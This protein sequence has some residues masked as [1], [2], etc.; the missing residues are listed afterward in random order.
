VA[1]QA[2]SDA[3]PSPASSTHLLDASM[4]NGAELAEIFHS[5]SKSIQAMSNSVT[6]SFVP[7]NIPGRHAVISHSK[8]A[9]STGGA[10]TS[11]SSTNLSNIIPKKHKFVKAVPPNSKILTTP[12][13]DEW[14]LR[15][16]P[17]EEL[18]TGTEERSTIESE[19]SS[20]SESEQ[21]TEK[22]ESSSGS[23]EDAPASGAQQSPLG[24]QTPTLR[25]AWKP[26]ITTHHKKIKALTVKKS[27]DPNL[28]LKRQKAEQLLR[29]LEP[30]LEL[31]SE[32]LSNTAEVDHP[33][34]F[35][36]TL[37]E[38]ARPKRNT[39]LLSGVIPKRWI[40]KSDQ[41]KRT[42][43]S[44]KKK[45]ANNNALQAFGMDMEKTLKSLRKS[46]L[47]KDA[48]VANEDVGTLL[49]G[50]LESY[51]SSLLKDA[52]ARGTI[53]TYKL[54]PDEAVAIRWYGREGF[55]Y[56]QPSLR[57]KPD[58]TLNIAVALPTA[59]ENVV[60]AC[61]RA[62]AKLPPLPPGTELFR[63][64]NY[65]F[66]DKLTPGDVYEDPAFVSTSTTEE[67]ARRKFSG[68]FL[69]KVANV[70][71]NDPRWRDI[72]SLTGNSKEAEVL[73]LPNAKFRVLSRGGGAKRGAG[74]IDN[75]EIITLEPIID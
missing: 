67:V 16:A 54:T 22:A 36:K 38:R 2:L 39:K 1:A 41:P 29:K 19:D 26:T 48:E 66:D 8:D 58:P 57:Q 6:K 35:S 69:L 49:T 63:G 13:L 64:T 72:A 17:Q 34:V 56:I 44:I 46:D 50:T 61:E 75:P 68:T 20:L 12:N 28:Q 30:S 65:L 71:E 73:C 18:S 14:L 7:A 15:N 42:A 55:Q 33:S 4:L 3:A 59:F 27:E 53:K 62:F 9:N 70:P 37:D 60:K 10:D 32:S 23:K 45:T 43:P 74:T 24:S 5:P 11:K 31:S 25:A 21:T 51:L 40:T 52:G 47:Y